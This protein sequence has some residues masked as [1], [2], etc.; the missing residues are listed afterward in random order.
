VSSEQAKELRRQGIAAAKAGQKDQARQLLQQSLRLE[1]NSEAG[2]LWLVSV[3][4]DQRE[5]LFCLNKLLDINP[6]NEMA[7][8]SLQQLGLTH[9]QLR[10][11]QQTPGQPVQSSTPPA[12]P[13]RSAP[14]P[15]AQPAVQN[16]APQAP[17]VPV[18]DPQRIAQAQAEAE[19]MVREYLGAPRTYPG[20]TWVRKTRRRAG[21]RDAMVL[22]LYIG[23]GVAVALIGLFIVGALVVLNNPELRGI[24]FAPT[25]TVSPTPAPPSNTPTPTPG[26]TPTPSSTPELTYTPSPTVPPEIP[27]GAQAAVPPTLIYPPVQEKGIRNSIALLDGGQFAVAIPTLNVEI[28]RVA[29]SFDPNPYYYEALAYIQKGDLEAAA[30]VLDEAEKRLPE[31]PND[32]FKPFIDAGFAYLDLKLAEQALDDNDNTEANSQLANVKDRAENAIEGDPRLELPYLALAQR[33]ALDR[34]YDLAVSVLDQGLAVPDLAS[35]VNL[36]VQKGQVYFQ[37]KEYDL[38][39]YQA[40]LALYINPAVEQ[41]HLLQ[42]RTAL[43]QDNPGLAVLN[44]QAYLF[45]Y[46]GSVEGYV[47]LGEARVAEGNYDL[48][49][50]AYNQALAGGDNADILVARAALYNRQR[51]FEQARADLSTAFTITKDPAIQA[52]RMLAA[53]NAGNT[54]TAQSD[55]EDLLG[56]GVIPDSE[57][58]LIQARILIDKAKPADKN[59]F[60]DALGLLNDIGNNLPDEL[61]PVANEYRAR[62]QYN[63][64]EYADA[65]RLVNQAL[66]VGE[67]GSRYYLRGLILEAQGDTKSALKDYDWVL[68]LSSVYPYPFLPDVRDRFEALQTPTP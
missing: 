59:D 57:I 11:A 45:Y 6:N 9:E 63:L 3:A 28:T 64:E 25:W 17:G 15:D 21:E 35:D 37:Q 18:A 47:L 44:A 8:Q 65:L 41:A 33:Y 2:W 48:A 7:L 12:A 43:A 23:A 58:Q 4:R 24:V 53:Y 60:T 62:A 34:D 32:N 22:R 19:Q 51:R 31:R 56:K 54:A 42:I 49:L 36:I 61:Q 20:V 27:N 67:T 5:R 38:A 39:S 16:P 30:Q 66:A 14:V 68:T 13:V 1:P 26:V 50:E 40:F 52:Q 29:S 46:P 55:A 10:Q